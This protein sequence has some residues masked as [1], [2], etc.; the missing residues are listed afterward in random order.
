M[1]N[2]SH[3]KMQLRFWA[4]KVN[5]MCNGDRC[6]SVYFS[7]LWSEGACDGESTCDSVC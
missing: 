2:I 4:V 7:E 3:I 6:V 5:E 1:L